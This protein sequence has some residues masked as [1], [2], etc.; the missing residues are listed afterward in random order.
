LLLAKAAFNN[1]KDPSTKQ[2]QFHVRKKP[3]MCYI[4]S[5]DLYGVENCTLQKVDQKYL[6]SFNVWC[7]RKTEISLTDLFVK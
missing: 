4:W 2:L 5:I 1:R 3:V 7:W 6:G